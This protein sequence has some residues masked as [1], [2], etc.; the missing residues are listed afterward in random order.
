MAFKQPGA[1]VQGLSRQC[2]MLSEAICHVVPGLH[3]GHGL[4]QSRLRLR[5]LASKDSSLELRESDLSVE[6]ASAWITRRAEKSSKYGTRNLC[7]EA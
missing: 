1:K 4:V 6:C 7:I 5:S 3:G 2:P